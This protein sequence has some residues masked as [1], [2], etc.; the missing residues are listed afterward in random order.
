[1]LVLDE[2][3]H[4]YYLHCDSPHAHADTDMATLT[5]V[6]KSRTCDVMYASDS[7]PNFLILFVQHFD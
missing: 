7:A 6:G 4:G 3:Y 1:M 5:Q 2:R